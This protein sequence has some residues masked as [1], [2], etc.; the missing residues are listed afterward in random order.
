MCNHCLS[1]SSELNAYYG[2]KGDWFN[3][4]RLHITSIVHAF[5][6]FILLFDKIVQPIY[7]FNRWLPSGTLVE[8]Q[9]RL[10]LEK[11]QSSQRNV[12]KQICHPLHTILL[13]IL[14][15]ALN[16][17]MWLMCPDRV[18]S[19]SST[20]WSIFAIKLYCSEN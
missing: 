4:G 20:F 11:P 18:L 2:R 3:Y 16:G 9:R 17:E 5:V 13:V 7:L 14:W 1:Q 12:Y 15:P 19:P 6:T 8:C 10:N